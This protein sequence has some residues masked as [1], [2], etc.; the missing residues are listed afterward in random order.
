MVAETNQINPFHPKVVDIDSFQVLIQI[1]IGEVGTCLKEVG[2]DLEEVG[3]ILVEDTCLRV[4]EILV[5]SY[6]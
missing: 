4:V 5:E 3:I 1:Q 2:I 6:S